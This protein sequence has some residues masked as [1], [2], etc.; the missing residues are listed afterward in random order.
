[1]TVS[2]DEIG[3]AREV[4]DDAKVGW[5][6]SVKHSNT[7][8][9]KTGATVKL[10]MEHLQHTGSFKIRGAYNK[11]NMV[12][13]EGKAEHVVTASAG[14][15]AQGVALSATVNGLDST[16]VMPRNAPESKIE[17][18][19]GYGG[20]VECVGRNFSEALEYA[21][22]LM[23]EDS[24]F[25]HAYDDKEIIAGQGTLGLELLEQV[26]DI[27]VCVLPIGGGGLIS[28]V[29][30]AL[31]ENDP[32]IRVVG[33]QA[34]DAAAVPVSL[35]EGHPVHIDEVNTIADGIATGGVSELTFQHI[36]KYVDEVVTVTDTE[37]AYS[38]L[39][40]LERTK[41]LVEGAGAVPIAA[42]MYRD[43]VN[44]G[45]IA[46]PVLSG[47]NM[48]PVMLQKILTH[49]LVYR[50]QLIK[51][52]VKI[53]DTPGKLNEISGIISDQGANIRNVSQELPYEELDVDEAFLDFDL[54]TSGP[55]HNELVAQT[56]I[57]EG[58]EVERLD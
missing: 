21:R 34:A 45:E 39:L 56:L 4:I 7:F 51:L 11:L 1:M 48:S 5:Q 44:D 49:G 24:V 37:I 10:K 53:L 35:D 40:L 58:F 41:Q 2:L 47:G 31:K 42:M 13:E 18:T 15:H 26:P 46:V 3:E 8:D 28:G 19:R 36:E 38:I 50:D 12:A 22:S 30:T 20:E 23:D 32:S 14:N 55:E 9:K 6:T 29:A 52:R 54:E 17:A 25:V 33:V 43:V 27:D 57:D 16:V